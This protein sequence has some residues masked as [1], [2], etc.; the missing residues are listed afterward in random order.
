MNLNGVEYSVDKLNAMEQL[1]L[2][3]K[4]GPALPILEGMLADRNANKDTRLLMIYL[5]SRLP[6]EDSDAVI[7]RCLAAVSRQQP[8]G[9]ARVMLNGSLMFQDIDVDAM[10]QLTSSVIEEN[11]GNFFNSILSSLPQEGMEQREA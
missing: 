1:Y 3:R 6:D 9:W 7:K 2:V 10:I 4:L 11:L 8:T 5:L